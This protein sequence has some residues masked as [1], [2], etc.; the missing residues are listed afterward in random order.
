LPLK[1]PLPARNTVTL[2]VPTL[3]LDVNQ[4]PLR[5]PQQ[6]GPDYQGLLSL[7]WNYFQEGKVDLGV[8]PETVREIT[9]G[10]P[11]AELGATTYQRYLKS[12]LYTLR[13]VQASLNLSHDEAN[14]LWVDLRGTL[15]HTVPDHDLSSMHIADVNQMFWHAVSSGST[16]ANSAFLTLD[17]DF[18]RQQDVLQN[19]YGITVLR[20]NIA[21]VEFRGPYNLV[22]P[23]SGGLDNLWNDQ[24]RYF[25][26]IQERST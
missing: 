5:P 3:T 25:A 15:F 8:T 23:P 16:A 20:P 19:R 14:E 22:V 7:E 1:F 4:I 2:E 12:K 26:A 21:W 13:P 6:L 17:Q 11:I 24:H 9:K 10:A 18:L